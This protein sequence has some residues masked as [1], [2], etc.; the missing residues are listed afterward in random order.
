MQPSKLQIVNVQQLWAPPPTN[1]QWA[2]DDVRYAAVG[3]K[4]RLVDVKVHVSTYRTSNMPRRS[5][6]CSHPR[7]KQFHELGQLTSRFITHAR[8]LGRRSVGLPAIFIFKINEGEF[9]L[10]ARDRV[11]RVER[12]AAS[13]RG[14][15]DDS[16]TRHLQDPEGGSGLSKRGCHEAARV[17]ENEKRSR[18]SN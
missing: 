14:V 15:T 13:Q 1:N 6:A 16:V 5:G 9:P 10:T 17:P 4:I 2:E 8:Q 7:G 11:S 3:A 12:S 18:T